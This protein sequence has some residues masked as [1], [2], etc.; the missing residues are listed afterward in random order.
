MKL[1]QKLK[2]DDKILIITAMTIGFMAIMMEDLTF[3][4]LAI[5]AWLATVLFLL[6]KE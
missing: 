2:T 4:I 3:K 5:L 6:V 1:Y